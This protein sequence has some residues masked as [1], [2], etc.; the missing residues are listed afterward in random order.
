MIN[1]QLTQPYLESAQNVLRDMAGIEIEPG[2]YFFPDRDD[3]I[4][5]GVTSI[6][7]FMGKIKGR[8]LI[9]MDPEL[10]IQIAH[11]IND[12]DFTDAKDFSVLTTISE[13]NNVIAG[14]ANTNLNNSF[15]L[16]L[17]LAPPIVFSGKKP[18]ICIPKITSESLDCYTKHGRLR[19][20]IAFEGGVVAK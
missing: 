20:N 6:I 9:D 8:L 4:S 3:I 18:I 1:S 17:R 19:I 16:G 10:A 14:K 11:N 12:E 13:V 7:T 5:Y 2:G 15:S